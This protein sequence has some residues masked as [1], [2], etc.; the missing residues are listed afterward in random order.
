[1]AA[2]LSLWLEARGYRR[3]LRTLDVSMHLYVRYL[4]Y[5]GALAVGL[6]LLHVGFVVLL[7]AK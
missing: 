6:Q 3:T 2:Y 1:M 5:G 4:I 7:P